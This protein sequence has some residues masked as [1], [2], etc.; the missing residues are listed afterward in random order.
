MLEIIPSEVLGNILTFMSS[1]S[2]IFPVMMVSKNM[3][4]THYEDENSGVFLELLT[5]MF[6][7]N[8]KHSMPSA[9]RTI[10]NEIEEYKTLIK[11]HPLFTNKELKVEASYRD[12]FKVLCYDSSVKFSKRETFYN[13]KLHTE[14]LTVGMNGNGGSKI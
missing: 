6:G 14:G 1:P 11:D 13:N 5:Y 2:D 8:Q 9:K 7:K 12:I 10:W 4:N 3:Y